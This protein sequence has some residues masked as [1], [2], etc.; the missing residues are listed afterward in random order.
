[1]ETSYLAKAVSA[2]KCINFCFEKFNDMEWNENEIIWI[3]K[4]EENLCKLFINLGI[5]VIIRANFTIRI[6]SV[7]ILN[8]CPFIGQMK[9][10]VKL[11]RAT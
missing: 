5:S 8:F 11:H 3:V 2:I 4:F 1:M 7:L 9:T 10:F 6:I